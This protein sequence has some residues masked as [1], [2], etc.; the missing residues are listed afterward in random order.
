[1]IAK[2]DGQAIGW[3]W[4]WPVLVVAGLLIIGYAV[5]RLPRSGRGSA[6]GGSGSGSVARRILDECYA[7]GEIDEQEY[8]HRWR[9]LR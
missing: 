4:V 8:Q 6:R 1:M 2:M 3:M 5:L 7:R 9:V